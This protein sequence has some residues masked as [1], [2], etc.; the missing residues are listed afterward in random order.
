MMEVLIGLVPVLL[1]IGWREAYTA[2]RRSKPDPHALLIDPRAI[3]LRLDDGRLLRA[4]ASLRD[5]FE[6]FEYRQR[7][8]FHASDR[9]DAMAMALTGIV[10]T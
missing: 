9:V 2:G 10:A 8:S 5:E 7:V 6:R 1:A 3:T 4:P